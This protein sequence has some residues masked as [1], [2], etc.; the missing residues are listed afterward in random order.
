M[1]TRVAAS[2]LAVFLV[3]AA[4]N[5]AIETAAFAAAD[6]PAGR[7]AA[8]IMPIATDPQN[9][10]A[11]TIASQS[12]IDPADEIIAV[13][14]RAAN[15]QRGSEAAPA[16]VQLAALDPAQPAVAARPAA[17]EPFGLATVHV[18]GGDVLTKWSKVA[19]EIRA[20]N[21]ILA[22][23]QAASAPCPTAAQSFLSIIAQGRVQTG[24]ARI[25]VINRAINLAIEP[26]SDFAQW[27]VADHWSAPLETFATG[28][29]DCEDYA[30]AKY[31]ALTAAGVDATDVKLVIVR[32]TTAHE[33]H[34]VVAVRLDGNWVVLDNRWLTLVE[35]REFPD[36]A[37]LFV[38][39]G[40]GVRQFA[41]PAL[42]AERP[43]S[44]P[45]S[46]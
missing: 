8:A 36:A 7:A 30:I 28:R 3:A 31:V 34:A 10:V 35:D 13:E 9:T 39:D 40:D 24:R 19:A 46:L 5:L 44:A 15:Q 29:G 26:T 42:A 2:S 37:P 33:D 41:P 45:A 43:A 25:G 1:L 20:G 38:L 21:E 12:T 18:A 14:A 32:N 11:E 27:G 22:R 6:L 16:I 17:A 23:C 4:G